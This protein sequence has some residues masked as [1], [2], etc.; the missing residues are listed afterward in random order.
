MTETPETADVS[1]A[2]RVHRVRWGKAIAVLAITAAMVAPP[3]GPANANASG[4]TGFSSPIGVLAGTVQGS[5]T[6]VTQ[7]SGSWNAVGHV[8]NYNLRYE[9]FDRFGKL[10]AVD[11][12]PIAYKCSFG[13]GIG[14]KKIAYGQGWDFGPGKACISLRSNNSTKAKVCFSLHS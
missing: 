9:Q 10:R 14:F 3:A 11:A 2:R 12:T 13:A 8:C 1:S 4:S 5:G 6:R 7:W